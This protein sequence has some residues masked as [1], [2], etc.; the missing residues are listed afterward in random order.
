MDNVSTLG[1]SAWDEYE[2]VIR[3]FEDAW[4]GPA[5]P[6]IIAFLPTGTGHTRL[7]TELVH[8][9]LE[10]RVRA[11]DAA[12]VEDYLTRYPELADD[13][14]A[15]LDL[16][17]AEFELRRRVEPG[18]AAA[19][20]LRRF[21]RYRQEM[22]D[23]IATV[24]AA[25]GASRDGPRRPADP[26][27]D[28]LPTVS[29]YEVLGELGRGGMG[30]V[31]LAR[32]L[33]LDRLCA[34]KTFSAAGGDATAAARLRAEAGAVAR[35]RHPNIVQIYHVGEAAGLPF[36]ELEYL[37]GGSLADAPNGAPR[38]AAEAA[39]LVEA[40]ARA[41]AESH[42]LG[43]VHR[44]LKPSNVLLTAAGEP[45]VGDFGLARSLASD[46]RLTH[47]G[48]LVGT[49]CYMAPEQAEPGVEDVG[50]AADVYSLGAIL[51]ELLTGH[52][53]FRAATTLQTLDLVRSREP[54]SP[55]QMQP[56]VPRDLE[57]IC[58]K[59]LHKDPGRRYA[60]AEALADDLGRFVR[61]RP[62][63]ARPT[64]TA[65]RAWKWARRHP[66]EAALSAALMMT[67]VLAFVLVSWQW[68][69]AEGKAAAEALAH[70]EARRARREAVRGQ[71]V[72]A[73]DH[74]RALCEQGELGQGLLWLARSQHL[75][76]EAREGGLDHAARVNLAEW[77]ARLGRP[78]ARLQ[79]P[80]PPLELAFRPDGRTLIA[81][82]A[83]GALRC[84]DTGT[85]RETGPTSS[86]DDRDARGD[87][88]GPLAFDPSG[89]GALVVFDRAGR[90]MFWDAVRHRRTGPTL[91]S[92]EGTAVRSAAFVGG[93]HHLIAC[94]ADGALRRWDVA[95]GRPFHGPHPSDGDGLSAVAVSPDGSA[96]VTGGEDGRVVRR[97]VR[98]GR[99]L[100]PT[101]PH[102]S[103]VRQVAFLG[104][105]RRIVV[106]TR[107][108]QVR[109]WDEVS[110]RVSL[111]PP[112]G[113]AVASLAVSPGGEWF[114]T[115]TEAG[116]VRLWDAA[117]LRQSG[118][119]FKLVGAVR[120]LAF[121]PDGRALAIG[122]EDRSIP[123][124]EVP[125]SGP[126]APPR[127]I[128]GPVRA[129]AFSRDGEH[130]LAVGG[131][132]PER[133][134]IGRRGQPAHPVPGGLP[135][136][137]DWTP[138]GRDEPIGVTAVS[139]D[140]RLIVAATAGGPGGHYGHRLTLID[141]ETGAVAG[142]RPGGRHPLAGIVFS[143][144]SR[145][146][147]TWGAG[148]ATISLHEVEVPE[149]A[150]PLARSL[151]VAVHHAAF[152]P[153][154]A[155]LLLGCRDGQARLWDVARDVEIPVGAHPYH[156]YPITAVAF[157]PRSPRVVTGCHAGTVRLWDRASGALLHDVRG[158][159]GEVPAV[160]FSPDGTTLLT[161]SLD[162]TARFWDV[163]SGR[164]LGPPLHHTD[165]VLCVAF[166]PD[167]RS[168][169]TGS[170][171]G[172]VW[173]WHAPAAPMDGDPAQID[174]VVE[175]RTGLRPLGR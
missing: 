70:A 168:V 37:P 46:V 42:R 167:G 9:D 130:L 126:I 158:N 28:V 19:D 96:L 113:A 155:T 36:L 140:G 134:C 82:G 83:D 71:A 11:G 45:K 32:N 49:P 23:K 102:G 72:L 41:V 109:T 58:L 67:A 47:T 38:P 53:P 105:G 87:F 110:L 91:T 57:T 66:A 65:E 159:A 146:L 93:G 145:R 26:R 7:L 21:P 89:S 78:L 4:K 79:A 24:I 142:D 139:P 153:D 13:R 99:P 127:L 156:A 141:A 166:H 160:A 50:P 138:D 33:S 175:Q 162:A 116:T 101:L 77:S 18:L 148:P 54:V 80:A 106:V 94:G 5:R 59:C 22:A 172:A 169:A 165:A 119:T 44:D 29:G 76:N 173:R 81:L 84:W 34:L 174:R 30:I 149:P 14:A 115:G 111:L 2:D 143:P 63:L 12:R 95:T 60:G 136:D 51:Y 16:I 157:D 35:L 108:G 117:T 161:A 170:R 150:R 137:A 164:Q 27:P 17:A 98:G 69:R 133:W 52:P 31:Y 151:G 92:P 114:A 74:G 56:A 68:R 39:Q 10:Y 118:A 128:R 154:G 86:A 61:G 97:D 152:S 8:V 107:D 25:G 90:G 104:N 144:D 122:L 147:L 48:Q 20:Y 75:A 73:M 163:E 171:D 15:A 40:V 129:V 120:C 62:I 103:P 121:P 123:I 1:G 55:R 125:W 112:E 135:R 6:E 64:G 43:I 100:G 124:R 131:R 85:W 132:G 88:V 3:R